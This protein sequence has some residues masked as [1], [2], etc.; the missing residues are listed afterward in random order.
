MD[1]LAGHHIVPKPLFDIAEK[2]IEKAVN[3]GIINNFFVFIAGNELELLMAH[4]NGE[5]HSDVHRIAWDTFEEA[6]NKALKLK[7][8]TAGQDLLKDEFCG[9]V[10][11]IGPGVAEMEI[12]ER[13]S[14]PIVVFCC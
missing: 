11:G 7:L 14:D 10:C 3:E 6:A 4:K 2:K 12:E 1:S 9:N 5:P 13:A 8:Y